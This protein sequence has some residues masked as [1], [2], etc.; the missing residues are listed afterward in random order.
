MMSTSRITIRMIVEGL[1]ES[2]GVLSRILSPRTV[3]AIARLLPLEGRAAVWQSEVYFEIPLRMGVEKPRENVKRGDLAY[4]P[5]GRAFCIF[6]EEMR[7]HT[8][9]NLIGQV[10]GNIEVFRRVRSG[11]K[12]RVERQI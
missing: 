2:E 8:P 11:T 1:G 5:L 12:I 10:T 4:W 7:P 9:V 6:F 3:D